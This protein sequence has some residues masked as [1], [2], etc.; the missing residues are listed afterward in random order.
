[1]SNSPIDAGTDIP[2]I[3][4]ADT[5]ATQLRNA[6]VSGALA[7]GIRVRQRDIAHAYGVSTTPVREAFAALQREGLLRLEA[8]KGAVVF[9]P[10][11]QD[12]RH[13]YEIRIELEAL[14]ARVAAL[15]FRGPD[16][17]VLQPL[18]DEMRSTT[19][20]TAYI[21]LNQRFHAGLYA[22]SGR[23]RLCALIATLRDASGAYLQ[24]Y[25]AQG[26]PAARL[27]R[28]HQAI[29]DACAAQ[30]PDAADA[31]VR[32]HLQ[33]T[34]EHVSRALEESAP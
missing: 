12:L 32:A 26:V 27:H 33:S 19:A 31:A 30:D 7:P 3:T 23:E 9:R 16:V 18:L 13:D 28:E 11:V 20:G 2:A 10:T 5:V 25:A 17:E 14:A 1:M 4:A 34:V 15:R 8:N 24:L 21:A 22:V 6:I 29:L